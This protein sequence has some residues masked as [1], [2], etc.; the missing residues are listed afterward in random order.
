MRY[1]VR[2]GLT[3]IAVFLAVLNITFFLPRMVPG[4]AAQILASSSHL[5]AQDT[6]IIS[7]R[8]GLN[9]PLSGQYFAY[10]KNIFLTWPPYFGVSYAYYPATVTDIFA[11]RIIWTLLLILSSLVFTLFLTYA[12]GAYSSLR[13]GGKFEMGSLYTSIVLNSVPTFWFGMILLLIFAI[14]YRIFPIFGNLSFNPGTG[15]DYA[16][17]VIWHALLPIITLGLMFTAQNYLLL[18]GSMQEVLNSDYVVAAKLRG[19]SGWRVSSGYILRNSLLPLI[20]VLSFSIAGLISRVILVEVV[21]GYS[22]VGDL[23][24]D[25]VLG[26]DYPVIEGSFFY[27]SLIVIAGGIIG[28]I[29]LKKLDPRIE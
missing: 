21:F 10:L 23:L 6:A 7:A 15:F 8:L 5:S 11:S 22:G 12:I 1:F 25:A 18:R 26:H 16:W 13:R 20:S 3:Y 14:I 27:L 4:N 24:V 28:D 19:L 29:V 9:L 2:R 17:D